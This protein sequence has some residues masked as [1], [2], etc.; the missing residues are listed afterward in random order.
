MEFGV[1]SIDE[2]NYIAQLVQ[3]QCKDIIDEQ[4]QNDDNI[5]DVKEYKYLKYLVFKYCLIPN[6]AL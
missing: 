1:G 2:L 3:K 5:S 6:A 4:I